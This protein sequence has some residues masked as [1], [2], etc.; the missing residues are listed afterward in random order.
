MG[1]TRTTKSISKQVSTSKGVEP[2]FQLLAFSIPFVQIEFPYYLLELS[3]HFLKLN[4]FSPHEVSKII[5]K[6]SFHEFIGLTSP[7]LLITRELIYHAY[8]LKIKTGHPIS[9]QEMV[10][11]S[12]FRFL[13]FAVAKIYKNFRVLT[14]T[15]L[16]HE[17]NGT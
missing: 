5:I 6:D 9:E 2:I 4:T 12:I 3:L 11:I 10:N 14:R 7:L 16:V 13:E 15:N 1:I 8:C 17:S